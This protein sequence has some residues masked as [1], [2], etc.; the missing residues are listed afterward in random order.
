[1]FIVREVFQAKPGKAKDLVAVFKNAKPHFLNMGAKGLR[2]MTDF[3]ANYWT[4]VIEFEINE[5]QDYVSM[6]DIK[7]A[8]EQVGMAMKG[9]MEYVQG[10]HREMFKVE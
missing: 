3:V 8:S 7:D 6:Y 9:Y 1:M 2:I 10:G 4:V 5:I